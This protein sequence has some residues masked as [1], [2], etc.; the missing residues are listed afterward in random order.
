MKKR[1]RSNSRPAWTP[2]PRPNGFPLDLNRDN[3]ST[4]IEDAEH[5]DYTSLARQ[6][7]RFAEQLV[8]FNIDRISICKEELQVVADIL[9][10]NVPPRPRGRP[11]RP[12]NRRRDEEVLSFV[13]HQMSENDYPKEAAVAAAQ[14]RF[15]LSRSDVYLAIYRY[16]KD[17]W[18]A[19][20]ASERHFDALREEFE[21]DIE[22]DRCDQDYGEPSE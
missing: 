21:Q 2:W 8:D 17:W 4:A 19:E 20:E 13:H 5:R 16:R 1:Q 15:G 18:A 3:A 14:E 22:R 12:A 9:E 10:G 11:A 6:L 7:R